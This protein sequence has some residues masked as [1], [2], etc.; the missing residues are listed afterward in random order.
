MSMAHIY[1]IVYQPKDQPYGERLDDFIRIPVERASLIAGQGI[2]GDQKAG[3][4]PNRQL[5]LLSH[6]WLLALQPKGHRTGPGHFG[7]QI[8]VAGLAVE[9]LQPGVRLQL[10]REACIEITRP[11]TGC[12]R[13][14]LAQGLSV[15]GLGPIG[16]LAR[17]IASG[18]IGVGDPVTVL[19]Q[20][21]NPANG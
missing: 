15:A 12:G 13:L 19:E 4:H 18:T 11:R 9:R 3:R 5:N 6:E 7:E 17:V 20:A 14:E 16:I 8:V 10:G 2:D 21:A 1:S